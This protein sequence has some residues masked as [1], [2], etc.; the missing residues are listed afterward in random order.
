MRPGDPRA[1]PTPRT[2]LVSSL[3]A[4]PHLAERPPPSEAESPVRALPGRGSLATPGAQG[5]SP[6]R[7]GR[8]ERWGRGPLSPAPPPAPGLGLGLAPGLGPRARAAPVRACAR[9]RG[10][11][12][13]PGGTAPRT[14]D[15]AV[16]GTQADGPLVPPESRAGRLPPQPGSPRSARL[17]PAGRAPRAPRA[18]PGGWA[19]GP[20]RRSLL[21]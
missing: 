19:A 5:S 18:P 3:T 6:P 11:G 12:R 2:E 13:G 7:A 17:A 20:A 9:D 14:A 21:A 10:P 1:E 4:R 15:A 16:L 8:G